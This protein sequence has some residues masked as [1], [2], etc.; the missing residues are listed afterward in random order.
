MTARPTVRELLAG[1]A[2]VL[3]PPHCAACGEPAPEA[4][5]EGCAQAVRAGGEEPFYLPG[6]DAAAFVGPHDGP[7]RE[8]ILGL[9]FHQREALAGP[10]A[11]LLAD[12][13][14]ELQPVWQ[15]EVV[16][17]I[18]CHPR[19]RR[20]RGLDHTALLAAGLARRAGLPLDRDAVRRA[21]YT[22]PQVRLLPDERRQNIDA[23]VFATPS[24]ERVRGRRLL[25]VDDVATTGATLA[26]CAEALRHAGAAAV[27]GITLSHGG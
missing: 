6:L 9:K 24:P 4:L 22:V 19:R 26:A 3:F 2:A 27:F 15:V 18:P 12:R 13:L 25:L 7:L 17:P 8:M 5:C 21:R 11:G 10:L 1:L 20:E 23:R 16:I 14:A